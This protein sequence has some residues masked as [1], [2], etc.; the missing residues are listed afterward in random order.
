MPVTSSN[1]LPDGERVRIYHD[2]AAKKLGIGDVHVYVVGPDGTSIAGLD[3]SP[4]MDT[5]KE[6]EFLS[7][8]VARL[9]TEPGPPV[10]PPHPQSAPPNVAADAPVIHLVSRR[11]GH[12]T[13]N[14]FPSE[15]WITLSKPEWDQI[16]P[17]PGAQ[18]KTTWQIPAPIAAKIAQWIYPQ[19]EDPRRANRSRVDVADFRLT[20]V[21]V[22]GSLVRARINAQVTILPA[23]HREKPL[24]TAATSE[25]IGFADFDLGARRVQRFR[26]VTRKGDFQ[27]IP[28]SCSLASVSKETIEAQR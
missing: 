23:F 22:S 19:I 16:L 17:P 3:I 6:I 26:M 2:F 15:N 25:L 5:D 20:V 7:G 24:E 13:W 12:G 8:I 10:F 1:Q 4:A 27:G 9:H 28:F 18:P 11:P 14:D 21:A